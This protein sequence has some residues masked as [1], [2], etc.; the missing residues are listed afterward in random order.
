MVFLFLQSVEANAQGNGNGNAW[1]LGI[2]IPTVSLIHLASSTNTNVSLG[3]DG[4]G[5]AGLGATNTADS[6]IWINYTFLKGKWTRPKNHIYVRISSG[7][8]PS[9]MSLKVKAKSA[10]THGKGNKG[11]PVGEVVLTGSD[12]K[13]IQNIKSSYTG[14]GAGKGHNLV[15]SLDL[16]NY[17]L[18]NYSGATTLTI[19][20]TISD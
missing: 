7:S 2:K 19:T 5:E 14:R 17:S 4:P 15:Y 8:M 16:T 9:G 10:T 6:S 20:Y 18:S 11:A 3:L 13:L 1:G 12:Q